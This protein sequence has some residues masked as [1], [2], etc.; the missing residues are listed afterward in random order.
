MGAKVYAY[1]ESA[2]VARALGKHVLKLQDQAI[3]NKGVFKIAVSGGS[4]GKALRRALIDNEQVASK[5][6]W[7]KWEVYFSD[8]RL[9]PLNHED[10][11]G[12]LFI[13]LVVEQLPK[14]SARPKVIS[15][16]ESL[17]TGKDGQVQDADIDKDLAIT[18]EYESKLPDD[19]TI[20]LVLLGCGPDGHTCSLFPGHPLLKERSKFIAYIKDSPKPPP[21]RIT[22][23]FPLLEKATAISFVAEG[24]GKAS[25]LK[26][27]FNNAK[28]QLPSKMVNDLHSDVS[29]FV[30]NEAVNGVDIIPAKY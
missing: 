1:D 11:N 10:S 17:V 28:S 18:S 2:E 21:R 30:N 29:W 27:V 4:L 6:Q 16:N 8:E 15:I 22:F 25:T 5:V 13:Q 7:D 20:D 9:V 3:E 12:G 14:G 24:A 26:E 23:T 19:K